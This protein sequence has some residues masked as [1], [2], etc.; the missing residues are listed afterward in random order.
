ML[1]KILGGIAMVMIETSNIIKPYNKA[2]LE[3]ILTE[4]EELYGLNFSIKASP[5][6]KV[7]RNWYENDDTDSF[8]LVYDGELIGFY[9]CT[10]FNTGMAYLMQIH[11]IN[12]YRGL[13][14]GKML[15]RHLEQLSKEND[16]EQI[17]FEVSTMNTQA[18]GFYLSLGY[19]VEEIFYQSG[20]Q[21]QYMNKQLK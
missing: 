11:I 10:I 19:E 17:N 13:G 9:L 2:Y 7:V 1:Y 14:Y 5:D 21:R 18:T 12:K 3:Q 4:Q 8:V 16:C 20:E 6:L 15:M